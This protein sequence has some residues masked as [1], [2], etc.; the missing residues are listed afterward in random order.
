M[1]LLIRSLNP[2]NVFELMGKD[3]NSATF[4]IGW[5]LDRSPWFAR[6]LISEIT[7]KQLKFNDLKIYLQKAG[8]D[9]GFTDIELV[10]DDHLHTIIEAK[11]GF[12]LPAKGQLMRYRRRFELSSAKLQKLISVSA[13][14]NQIAKLRLPDYID[15]VPVSHISWG[16]IRELAI[17]ARGKT[18]SIEEK[19]WLR[20]LIDHLEE[21]SAMNINRDNRVYVVSLGSRPMRSDSK[22]TW[23]DVVEQDK[24]YFHQVGNHWP[25]QPPN[26]IGFRYGGMLQSVHR[27]ESYEIVTDVSDINSS[28]CSTEVDHFVYKLGPAMKPPRPLWAGRRNDL[29]QRDLRVWCAIDT[30]LS[31]QFEQLG[32]ARDETNERENRVRLQIS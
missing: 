19:M 12:E 1:S 6:M 18:K 20:E 30:L 10:C 25:K 23:I 29:I 4:S 27:I 13:L 2:N 28:W 22:R 17:K 24:C 9:K 14:P 7:D 5:V 26:Y 15:G 16:L 32:Q 31:G 8:S 21:Y 3:E 11:I